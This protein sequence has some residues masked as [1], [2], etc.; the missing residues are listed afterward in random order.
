MVVQ[1]CRRAHDNHAG[2]R[3]I[4]TCLRMQYHGCSNVRECTKQQS[5]S[6]VH[7]HLTANERPWFVQMCVSA[8]N[9]PTSYGFSQM[10]INAHTHNSQASQRGKRRG[11]TPLTAD[12]RLWLSRC[13]KA[14]VTTKQVRGAYALAANLVIVAA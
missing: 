13:A 7:V 11:A 14:H 2:Q 12:E 1:V 9:N 3:C 10:C 8:H 4:R 6:D 5:K